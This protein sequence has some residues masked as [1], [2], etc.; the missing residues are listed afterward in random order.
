MLS[1]FDLRRIARARIKDAQALV[2]A[3]RFDGAVYLCGYAVE[4]VL[5]ARICATLHWKDFPSTTREFENYRSFRTQ[6]LDVL[7][8]LSG[9]ESKI[10]TSYLAEW[11]V[12][13][14]WDPEARY[15]PVGSADR[16]DAELM[17]QSAERL[18]KIL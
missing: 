13:A 15:K 17:I 6:N 11:S 9:R 3:R 16:S 5:K 2:R 14:G 7:L 12:V 18:L 10:K 1:R 8:T 4:L